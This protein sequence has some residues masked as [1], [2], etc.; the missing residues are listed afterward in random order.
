MLLINCC[1][2]WL[3][4]QQLPVCLELEVPKDLRPVA[5]NHFWKCFLL[6]IGTDVPVHS[7][8]LYFPACISHAA[9]M[10]WIVCPS[11]EVDSHIHGSVIRAWSC[12]APLMFFSASRVVFQNTF[13]AFSSPSVFSHLS[14]HPGVSSSWC[15][16]GSSSFHPGSWLWC[17]L[18]LSLPCFIAQR[19]SGCRPWVDPRIAR[20]FCVLTLVAAISSGGQLIIVYTDTKLDP[21]RTQWFFFLVCAFKS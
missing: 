3:V 16:C 4:G 1:H 19:A 18:I 2:V 21:F 12:I 13:F 7:A 9:P 10:C 15:I 17:S 11:A 6:G 8:W 14:V 20:R 5:L